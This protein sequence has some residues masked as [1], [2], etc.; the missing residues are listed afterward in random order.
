MVGIRSCGS[1]LLC[2]L[3]LLGVPLWA[4]QNVPDAPVPKTTQTNQFP[5]NAPPALKNARPADT[6]PAD[7]DPSPASTPVAAGPLQSVEGLTTDLKQ[8]GKISVAVNFVQVPVTVKDGAGKL[9]EGLG[10][11]DF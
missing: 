9:Q 1:T 8:F 10:P 4:Q 6:K 7:A 3:S 11:A 2:L 5:E